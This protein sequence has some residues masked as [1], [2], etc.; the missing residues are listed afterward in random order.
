MN[1]RIMRSGAIAAFAAALL[2]VG[3]FV[4]AL[5]IGNDYVLISKSVDPARMTPFLSTHGG[6]LTQVM[7]LDDGFAIAYGVAFV[8][9]ALYVM[10]RAKG[11]ALVAL[12]FA[13]TTML[14]DLAENSLTLG[15][16]QTVA[17]GQIPD[18]NVLLILFWLGQ[19]KY[20]AIYFAGILFAVGVWD[21]GRAG[22]IFGVL[23]LVF[24]LIGIAS[25]SIE[26]LKIVQV[27]WMLVMLIAGGIF[28]W[29]ARET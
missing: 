6:A 26:A 21:A 19:I 11:L 8:A 20:L 4:L 9:L 15:A 22:K 17:Q 5:G 7:T 27:L 2:L 1:P 29:R 18:A 14:T 16:V 25:I 23:L 10:P 12:V 24:P 3:Q 28:L 13:L